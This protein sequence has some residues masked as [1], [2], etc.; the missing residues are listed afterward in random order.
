[1]AGRQRSKTI[2]HELEA[3]IRRL[4]D[5]STGIADYADISRTA[6]VDIASRYSA[7]EIMA[8][9]LL[10]SIERDTRKAVKDKSN[11]GEDPQGDMFGKAQM[12]STVVVDSKSFCKYSQANADIL[13]KD[14]KRAHENLQRVA[15]SHARKRERMEV[16]LDAGMRDKPD[17]IVSEAVDNIKNKNKD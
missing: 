15:A 4:V 16:L 13:V 5:A 7:E 17:M 12:E 6:M 1:M 9:Y 2:R 11:P 14:E 3:T 10:P 8:A